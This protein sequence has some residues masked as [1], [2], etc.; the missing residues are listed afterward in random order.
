MGRLKYFGR[1]H[2]FLPFRPGE[3]FPSK[4]RPV[5]SVA[6]DVFPNP[7]LM[8]EIHELRS[9]IQNKQNFQGTFRFV[10]GQ[11]TSY[12]QLKFTF[13][14]NQVYLSNFERKAAMFDKEFDDNQLYSTRNISN[15]KLYN[16]ELKFASC[17]EVDHVHV[18][19]F[20]RET[21]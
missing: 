4:L 15:R 6:T 9:K 11:C 14:Q 16:V 8:Y 1:S 12:R 10:C 7:I 18:D 19:I 13:L 5:R 21:L 20:A 17:C 2:F 3:N